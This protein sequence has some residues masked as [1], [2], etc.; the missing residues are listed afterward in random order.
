VDVTSFAETKF[1]GKSPGAWPA[2][3]NVKNRP[4]L[5]LN[6]YLEVYQISA[7]RPVK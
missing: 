4:K 1:D 6:I 3:A 5:I 7:H 2:S